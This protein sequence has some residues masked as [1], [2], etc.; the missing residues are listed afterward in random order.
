MKRKPEEAKKFELRMSCEAAR[1]IRQH[2]RSSIKAEVC[3]VLIGDEDH[4]VT[5]V[6]ASIPGANATQGG[7]HVTFTQD[8]W[9][10][11]YRIKDRD[12]PE[13]RIVGW[14]HSHPGFGVFLSDHDTFIHKNFFSAPRQVAWV[15][16]PHS[17]EEG[18][19]GWVG[20]KLERIPQI[21]FV[22]NKGGE[23]AGETGKPEP[24]LPGS[25]GDEAD[26]DFDRVNEF[27][28]PPNEGRAMLNAAVTVIS[29]ISALL[30]GFLL[31]WFLF[32]RLVLVPVDSRTGQPLYGIPSNSLSGSRSGAD[33]GTV[34]SPAPQSTNPAPPPQGTK[35]K[36]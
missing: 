1:R 14:Y 25:G 34:N 11:I 29:Y 17:D 4:G 28:H 30:I 24:L 7:S 13:A 8:T 5:S 27:R 36:P 15:Y 33:E 12:Y 31:S 26:S 32:P 19:F 10:H 18:C 22:D 35:G 9:E 23:G 21:V 2:A 6:E 3:G 16:D 20:E